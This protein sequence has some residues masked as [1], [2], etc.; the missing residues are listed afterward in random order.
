MSIV[1]D[2][3][4]YDERDQWAGGGGTNS[5]VTLDVGDGAIVLL[6]VGGQRGQSGQSGGGGY[7]D[8][9]YD[10][11]YGYAAGSS[12]QYEEYDNEG[13]KKGPNGGFAT[14]PASQSQGFTQN[15]DV[16]FSQQSGFSQDHN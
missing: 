3:S 15:T 2:D 7:G 12:A 1:V 11:S 16:G 13:G 10:M 5:R 8:D 4:L 14:Q 6:D 9:D